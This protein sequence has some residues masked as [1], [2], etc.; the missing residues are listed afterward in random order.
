M[1]N[2]VIYAAVSGIDESYLADAENM[3]EIKAEFQR[4]RKRKRAAI[5]GICACFLVIVGMIGIPKIFSFQSHDPGTATPSVIS[6]D[7]ITAEHLPTEQNETQPPVT[8]P[9]VIPQET[10]RLPSETTQSP[11]ETP[12]GSQEQPASTAPTPSA[13]HT[14]PSTKTPET[15]APEAPVAPDDSVIWGEPGSASAGAYVL[16]NGKQVA[17]ELWEILQKDTAG[18][19]IAI[20]AS[21]A[22]N[23]RF[24]YNGKTIAQ[25]EAEASEQSELPN[26]LQQLLKEGEALK[27]GEALYTTG[28]PSGEKWDKDFYEKRIAYYGT[29][30]LSKY[31]VN[32][33][34][35]ADQVAADLKAA[36]ADTAAAFAYNEAVSAYYSQTS[37]AAASAL[38]AAGLS[39]S[40]TE[41]GDAMILF[42]SAERFARLTLPGNTEWYYSLAQQNPDDTATR[43]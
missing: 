19:T 25:Y 34:F 18:R 12:S 24:V 7:T 2:H 16:W 43:A 42:A 41:F 30:L 36:E 13:G 6:N 35:L 5:I 27:H 10:E 28:T 14:E 3:S 40:V 8:Q 33:N 17:Y 39:C 31:I 1:K 15:A 26:K 21:P 23:D 9:G 4:D 29:A 37:A 38:S 32:G 22:I 11:H 20:V